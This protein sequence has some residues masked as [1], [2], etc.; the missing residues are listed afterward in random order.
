[1]L[2]QR[3]HL[4]EVDMGYAGDTC[5]D[6]V[7]RLTRLMRLSNPLP[8]NGHLSV[9]R[10]ANVHCWSDGFI[11]TGG[12]RPLYEVRVL[13]NVSTI[14]RSRYMHPRVWRDLPAEAWADTPLTGGFKPYL[15]RSYCFINNILVC[16]WLGCCIEECR[17]WGCGEGMV[18]SSELL[19]TQ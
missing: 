6:R 7:C 3:S 4:L 9:A 2:F 16:S 17:S 12:G 5:C 1:M 19:E 15:D 11:H 14:V 13:S 10:L 18:N 8:W